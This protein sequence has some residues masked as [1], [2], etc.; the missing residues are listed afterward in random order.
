MTEPRRSKLALPNVKVVNVVAS[1][2]ADRQIDIELLATKMPHSI[3]E[4][5]NFPGLIHRRCDPKASIIV[6]ST[7]KIVS[8]G[9]MSEKT[10]KESIIVTISEIMSIQREKITVKRITI[11]NVVA[12]SNIGCEIDIEKAVVNCGIKAIY[13]PE[14]FPG[15][16]YRVRNNLVAL[17]FKSGKIISVGSKS[18][19][20]ARSIIHLTYKILKEFDCL[21]NQKA[22]DSACE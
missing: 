2:K 12:I 9:S 14:K 6:F 11:E 13:E 16:I 20:E 19:D 21:L 17:I 4:P 15:V 5:E 1:T 18:E 7:G 10:A 3:Y 8:I 22:E